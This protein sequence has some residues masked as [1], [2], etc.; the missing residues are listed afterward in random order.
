MELLPY[1]RRIL[2]G[3]SRGRL[4]D[5]SLRDIELSSLAFEGRTMDEIQDLNGAPQT[6]VIAAVKRVRD[7]IRTG[8]AP[9]NIA[10]KFPVIVKWQV[11][12][13]PYSPRE[14]R[15]L[16]PRM[17]SSSPIKLL[18]SG[19]GVAVMEDEK[20]DPQLLSILDNI[21]TPE[22]KPPDLTD[23]DS[24]EVYL[25]QVKMMAAKSAPYLFAELIKAAVASGE[26]MPLSKALERFYGSTSKGF[27]IAQQFNMRQ[28]GADKGSPT[29]A[30]RFED[31]IA[32]D[33]SVDPRK[34]WYGDQTKEIDI[35]A[36]PEGDDE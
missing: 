22:I 11:N 8:R 24:L 14:I 4:D 20:L 5:P 10:S 28:G 34:E 23:P 31:I 3:V 12:D 19:G 36:L 29:S 26:V 35:E 7:A 9:E 15:H 33:E 13:F 1:L 25:R 30:H 27:T 17:P 6:E 2:M 18:D 32:Q 16:Q 21:K